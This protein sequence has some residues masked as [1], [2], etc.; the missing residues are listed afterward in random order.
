MLEKQAWQLLTNPMSLVGRILKTKYFPNGD[1]LS[2][3]V[4]SNPSLMWR[5]IV[6]AKLVVLN[7]CRWKVGTGTEIRV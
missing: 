3:N 5:S 2:A 4:G 7:G 1:F 6:E